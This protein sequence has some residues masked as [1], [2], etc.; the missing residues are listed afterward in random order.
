[1]TTL[2]STL[3]MRIKTTPDCLA[4]EMGEC[5]QLFFFFFSITSKAA[6]SSY[7]TILLRLSNAAFGEVVM[8]YL[9]LT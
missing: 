6:S 7:I 9:W 1:M 3:F 8:Y 5:E 4:Y 2:K